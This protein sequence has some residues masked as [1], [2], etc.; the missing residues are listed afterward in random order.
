M[1]KIKKSFLFIPGICFFLLIG[2]SEKRLKEDT[3]AHD[4]SDVTL[5]STVVVDSKLQQSPDTVKFINVS[6]TSRKHISNL[7]KN[8]I[9]I[10][11]AL[12]AADYKKAET[13]SNNME[14]EISRFNSVKDLP[15][16]QDMFYLKVGAKLKNNVERIKKSQDLEEQRAHFSKLTADLYRIVH[17]FGGNDQELYYQYCPMAFDNNGAYWLSLNKKIENPYFGQKMLHCGVVKETIFE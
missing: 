2:C 8:Y 4:S 11:N 6:E 17:A 7:V 1:K 14:A 10:K 9:A 13:A 15:D 16:D 12:V 3:I 5:A